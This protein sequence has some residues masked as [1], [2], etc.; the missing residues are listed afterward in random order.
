MASYAEWL[1]TYHNI[2]EPGQNRC[3]LEP[4]SLLDILILEQYGQFC[5]EATWVGMECAEDRGLDILAGFVVEGGVTELD[6]SCEVHL[7]SG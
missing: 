3:A 4:D 6:G 7:L 5:H 2:G 1:W